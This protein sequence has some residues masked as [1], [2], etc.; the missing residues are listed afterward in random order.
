MPGG[1]RWCPAR[2]RRHSQRE[3]KFH[4]SVR[5]ACHAQCSGNRWGRQAG[6]NRGKT[7]EF[8]VGVRNRMR[9]TQLAGSAPDAEGPVPPRFQ[10]PSSN[11]PFSAGNEKMATLGRDAA[12]SCRQTM[13]ADAGMCATARH[14]QCQIAQGNTA[15][16]KQWHTHDSTSCYAVPLRCHRL[17]ASH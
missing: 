10:S 6:Q 9:T 7:G 12:T 13:W 14:E 1:A 15:S 4:L 2:H 5:A 16:A 11:Q 3:G 17:C 8:Q